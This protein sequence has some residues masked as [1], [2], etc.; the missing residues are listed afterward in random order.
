MAREAL[1]FTRRAA[2]PNEAPQ[3]SLATSPAASDQA[4]TTNM[5]AD[6]RRAL[7]AEVAYYRSLRCADSSDVENWLA[8]EQEVN[9]DLM[10]SQ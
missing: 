2:E 5:D 9:A 8:A 10:L 7:I 6:Q 3:T 1:K 4:R